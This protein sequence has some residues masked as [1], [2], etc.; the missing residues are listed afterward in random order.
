MF[1]VHIPLQRCSPNAHPLELDDALVLLDDELPAL[2]D[3]LV[4]LDALPDELLDDA[5]DPLLDDALVLLDE[6]LDGAP[7]APPAP[8]APWMV[9]PCAHAEIAIAAAKAP[10]RP[11]EIVRRERMRDLRGEMKCHTILETGAAVQPKSASARRLFE[12]KRSR[13]PGRRSFCG[14]G[15]IV[16]AWLLVAAPALAGGDPTMVFVLAP[17]QEALLADALGKGT[18]LPG[19]C[20][21]DGAD[22]DRDIVSSRYVCAPGDRRVALTLTLAPPGPERASAAN[23]V[24]SIESRDAPPALIAAVTA[25]ANERAASLQWSEVQRQPPRVPEATR[26]LPRR[27]LLSVLA[28]GAA[29]ALGGLGARALLR[30]MSRGEGGRALVASAIAALALVIALHGASRAFFALLGAW[31][32][33]AYAGDYG[34]TSIQLSLWALLVAA[35]GALFAHVRAPLP[36]AARLLLVALGYVAVT[37]PRSLIDREL[38]RFGKLSTPSPAASRERSYPI[39]QH[40]F[41]GPE[42]ALEKLPG[43]VRVALVGDS[44]V[45]GDLIEAHETSAAA[46]GAELGARFPGRRFEVLNLGIAGDNLGSHV[47]MFEEVTQRLDPDV[48]IMCLTL[49]NDLT[50]WDGQT[51][52]RDARRPSAFSLVRYWIGEPAVMLFAKA[53]LPVRVTPREIAFAEKELARLSRLRERAPEPGLLLFTFGP[54]D[55]SMTAVMQRVRGAT[56]VKVGAVRAGDF[57]PGDGHPTGAGNKRFARWMAD[58]IEADAA[59]LRRI[60]RALTP[61]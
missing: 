11:V 44:F 10:K 4:L 58:G 43:T 56:I 41:R 9:E 27:V 2:D 34:D 20:R 53:L 14:G 49:P 47:D 6:P 25:R 60:P 36:R 28:A 59:S 17:G 26:A 54:A 46:L 24:F 7:P 16:A 50:A 57:I 31:M 55:P 33:P 39:N 5:F 3:A 38:W 30:R 48:I 37:Y 18:E 8:P 21:W 13:M 32:F 40:G 52:R 45:A 19:G 22:V 42:F 61:R 23:A 29:V 51:E 1:P 35:A 15:P 12:D